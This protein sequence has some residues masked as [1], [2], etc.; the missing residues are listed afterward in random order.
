V[1]VSRLLHPLGAGVNKLS[2]LYRTFEFSMPR[3]PGSPLSARPVPLEVL[4]KL[5][6]KIQ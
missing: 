1:L 5:K 2:Q 4:G 6:K 3:H